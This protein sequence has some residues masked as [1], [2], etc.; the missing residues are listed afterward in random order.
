MDTERIAGSLSMICCC[1]LA[2]A[3]A[4]LPKTDAASRIGLFEDHGDVGNVLHRGSVKF[5][6]AA[7]TYTIS[8]S[9]D[10]MWFSND[11]F[12]FV[13]K[14][15]TGDVTLAAD[16]AFEGTGGNPH[17]KAVLMVRQSL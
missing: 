5:D 1:L 16:I 13:W 14:K 3:T 9:G 4:V 7:G 10:N 15:V 6:P 12:Q 11:E 17:R 2:L 8:G